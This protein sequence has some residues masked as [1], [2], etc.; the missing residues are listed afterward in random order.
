MNKFCSIAWK[1]YENF[2]KLLYFE[3]KIIN[4]LRGYI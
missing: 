2:M 3:Y 1:T 4:K